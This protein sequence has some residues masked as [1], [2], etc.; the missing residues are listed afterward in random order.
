MTITIEQVTAFLGWSSLINISILLVSTLA[1]VWCRGF[2]V[3]VHS[4]MFDLDPLT[5][6]AM[7][8]DYLG[9]FK[10]LVIIFNVVPYFALRI[11]M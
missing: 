9:R 6:P 5:L 11:M 2:A 4:K 1:V 8:F 7:Y 10:V 3:R